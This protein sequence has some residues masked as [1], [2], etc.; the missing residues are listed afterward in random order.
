MIKNKIFIL[1]GNTHQIRAT[2]CLFIQS[3]FWGGGGLT[4]KTKNEICIYNVSRVDVK[5][6]LDL[7]KE[8]KNI[9][10]LIPVLELSFIFFESNFFYMSSIWKFTSQQIYFMQCSIC[11]FSFQFAYCLK[12]VWITHYKENN[13]KITER[14]FY[15]GNFSWEFFFCR[16]EF[17][18]KTFVTHNS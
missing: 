7:S 5:S 14:R 13:L 17:K 12:A 6:N 9:F 16:M 18:G 1:F 11:L 15:V 3:F 4:T 2:N 8:N 10:I